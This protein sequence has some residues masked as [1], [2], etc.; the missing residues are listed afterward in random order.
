M[1]RTISVEFLNQLLVVGPE[2]RGEYAEYI[3]IRWT[4]RTEVIGLRVDG[5]NQTKKTFSYIYICNF[6]GLPLVK[7]DLAEKVEKMKIFCRI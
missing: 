5:S 2:R 1:Y 4:P 6:G 3:T 7:N